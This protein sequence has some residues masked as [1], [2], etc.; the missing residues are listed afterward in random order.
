[1]NGEEPNKGSPLGGLER[2]SAVTGKASASPGKTAGTDSSN[3]DQRLRLPGNVREGNGD[4]AAGGQQ[5]QGA[6]G[7]VTRVRPYQTS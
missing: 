4:E 1:M 6:K 2:V 7:I 3:S 5:H